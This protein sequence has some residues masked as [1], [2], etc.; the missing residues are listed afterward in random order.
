[1]A[2]DKNGMVHNLIMEQ[3]KKIN[4]SGVLEV[5][6]FDEDTVVLDTSEGTLTVKGENLIINNF[7]A[8]TG[9]LS[10]GGRVYAFV[11]SDDGK[12]KGFLRRLLK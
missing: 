12:S 11:Y 2:E 6:G 4:M 5:K 9:E 8:T 3:C 10:M 7:S 1:M